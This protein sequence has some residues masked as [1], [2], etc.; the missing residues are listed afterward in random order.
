[1][2]RSESNNIEVHHGA[3]VGLQQGETIIHS[4]SFSTKHGCVAMLLPTL[5]LF[6]GGIILIT[7][8]KEKFA[9]ANPGALIGGAALIAIGIG[10][11][12]FIRRLIR[13]SK[14][15]TV[16]VTNLRLCIRQKDFW[17]T[18]NDRDIPIASVKDASLKVR[19]MKARKLENSPEDNTYYYVRYILVTL[20]NNEDVYIDV[21]DRESMFAAIQASIN[22]RLNGLDAMKEFQRLMREHPCE[23]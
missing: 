6:F 18:Q 20:D 3:Q 15:N 16:I 8:I 23:A 11:L 14:S 1:M 17:G 9:Y 22:A 4:D 10:L 5:F 19:K 7:Q 21:L 13:I 2:S 12:C